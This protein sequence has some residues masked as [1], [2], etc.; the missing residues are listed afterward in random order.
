MNYLLGITW[1]IIAVQFALDSEFVV[2]ATCTFAAI[3][4]AVAVEVDR[5]VARMS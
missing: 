3:S 4:F 1:S 5:H 2:A